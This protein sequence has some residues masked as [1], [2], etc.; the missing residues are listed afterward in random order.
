MKKAALIVSLAATLAAGAALAHDGKG[1]GRMAERLK[2]ADT[3]GD[4]LV[5]KAE[6]AALPRLAAHF[7][8]I[9]AN[10]DGQ[11]SPDELRAAHAARGKGDKGGMF[12][13]TDADNDGRVSQQEFVAKATER[14]QRV[15]ANGGGFISQEEAAAARKG[16]HHRHG[17]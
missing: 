8:A 6:A 17:G 1:P 9:D 7:D 11:L 14:F 5:S 10:K 16:R 2:A 15:D 3:N 13:R 12:A 4:G